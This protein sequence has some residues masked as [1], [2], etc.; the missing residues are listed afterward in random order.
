MEEKEEI[1]E[2]RKEGAK[3]EPVGGRGEIQKVE[4]EGG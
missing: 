3:E 2:E 4:K 1:E